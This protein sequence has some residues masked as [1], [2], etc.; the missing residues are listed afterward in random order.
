MCSHRKNKLDIYVGTYVEIELTTG[1]NLRGFLGY[2]EDLQVWT[3]RKP[4]CYYID[5]MVF[6]KSNVKNVRRV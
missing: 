2:Q 6:R 3:P 1:E 4:N 5:Q